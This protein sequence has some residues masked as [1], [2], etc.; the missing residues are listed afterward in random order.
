MITK[1][2]LHNTATYSNPIELTE[3]PKI[4]FFFGSNGTGKTTISKLLANPDSYPSCQVKW[5]NEKLKTIVYN[6]D[7]VRRVFYQS[8]NLPGIFTMGEEAKDIEEKIKQ[9]NDAKEQL[10]KEKN[11]LNATLE[12]KNIELQKKENNFRELC[13]KKIFEKYN[14]TFNKIFD[15]YRKS[16][17]KLANYI[18][19]QFSKNQSELKDIKDINFLKE[20]YNL[21]YNEEL[22][23][24][25]EIIQLTDDIYNQLKNL[26][27]NQILKTKIIGKDDIDIAKMIEK[28]HNHDWVRQGKEYY[29]QNFDKETNSYICP[30][31]QQKTTDD[32]KIKLEEYFDETYNNQIKEVNQF[33][34]SYSEITAKIGEYFDKL[35]A[36]EG[37]KYFEREKEKI[38]TQI[39]IIHGILSEN[40]LLINKKIDKPSESVEIKSI[41]KEHQNLKEL[42]TIINN[43]IV[44][45]NNIVNNQDKE[46]Q[47]LNSEIWKYFCVD[48]KNDIESY[49]KEKENIEKAINNLTDQINAQEKNIKKIK[50]EILNLEKQIKS[51]KPTVDAINK[52]LKQFGF[53]SFKLKTSEDEKHYT[54]IRENGEQAKETLSE[55]ERNF[56][57]FLY[58][59]HLVQGTLNPEENINEPKVI[60]FDDPVSSLDSDVLFIVAALIKDILRKVRKNEGNI[61]QVFVL[62][63]N[64][65]F[66]K[67]VTYIST[68]ESSYQK[69]NNT[70]Y[71][72]VRKIDNV[73][74][75]ESYEIN[76]IKTTYQVLWDQLKKDTD[77]INIQN[78]MRRI[79][80][81]YFKL[82]ADMN[83]EELIG[84]FE[85]ENDKEICR[86]LVSWMNVGSHDVFSDIDYSPKPEEIEKFKQV[87]KGIF[88]KTGH[89]AH[90]NMMM[91]IDGQ[92]SGS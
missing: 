35:I 72:I 43:E 11:Q 63:H 48:I 33:K 77:C 8:E 38:K 62:T 45:H 25:S 52:L 32:F 2:K 26:E 15:G 78:T 47:T 55:G 28:L 1:I 58:F 22:K 56:I 9:K 4:N 3:L 6:E 46:K 81:F 61:K 68:R 74:N 51:V 17:E 44:K 88:E 87:F 54:I 12:N 29:E 66:F 21:L 67:E 71:Y 90:Y 76:P 19:N 53:S 40:Q 24:I 64:T 13:W 7:F 60:V 34:N 59:Y 39:Q 10:N 41:I 18:L 16:K 36:I 92:N 50:D 91:G 30:F 84:K 89:I 69:R 82:L 23:T 42:I 57:V 14:E 75:I 31:C 5:Q 85:D 86:S 83:E 80:E 20:R 73:S 65:F 27:S 79:I 70:M 49:K 37:N